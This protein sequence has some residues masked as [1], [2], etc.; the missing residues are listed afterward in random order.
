MR[1]H[2]IVIRIG[3]NDRTQIQYHKQ[4][5]YV[6]EIQLIDRYGRLCFGL[7]H[8]IE[9][10]EALSIP[11]TETAID[12]GLLA[13]AVTA[14]DTRISRTTESQDSWT[15]EVDIY[16]PVQNPDIWEKASALIV[17]MLNFLTG[18]RWRVFFRERHK[19]YPKLLKSQRKQA[20]SQVDC[21][22]LLSGGLDSFIGAIDL[23]SVG[24]RPLF[25]SHYWDISTSS[26]VTCLKRLGDAFGDI[27][28]RHI[29]VRVGF[30][31]DLIVDSN[32][33]D[34]NRSRS[35]LFFALAAIAGS[36]LGKFLAVYVPENGFISLN[37]PLDPL[38]IGAWSTRTTH[39]F[40][41]ARWVDLTRHLELPIRWD[42][43]YRFL[44]KGEM[45]SQCQ[46]VS[47]LKRNLRETISCSSY[48]KS[49]WSEDSLRQCG[50]C[51]PC[52]IRRGAVTD[53]FGND[54]TPYTIQNLEDRLLDTRKAEGR[55]VRSI[56]F[57]GFRLKQRPEL[58]RSLIWKSGPLSDCNEQ[59]ISKY[60]G[61][62]SRGL[63]EVGAFL[64]E[65]IA[66]PV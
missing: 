19:E 41:M 58:A 18:D 62:F 46:D 45:L 50:Y 13:A 1:H 24:A 56:Q 5:T 65:V 10:L 27:S 36:G 11:P 9:R 15:R 31:N 60:E 7:G 3:K 49:R 59:E 2:S 29:R 53:A 57:L 32:V 42:N 40:Y 34:T 21:L 20:K 26:Q 30:P 37:V 12:L 61:V 63:Q 17:R 8:L 54:P 16:L 23:L 28:N 33:E 51:F 38:R 64:S 35:F 66:G 6:T 52:L 48:S 4:S 22:C 55:D 44:T 47:F 39:P 14:S 43:P 25:V